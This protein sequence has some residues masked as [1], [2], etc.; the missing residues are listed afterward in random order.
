[1]C[2]FG[3]GGSGQPGR[4][5]SVC[6]A[7]GPRGQRLR[8]CCGTSAGVGG[9]PGIGFPGPDVDAL[10]AALLTDTGGSRVVIVGTDA[11][12]PPAGADESPVTLGD[13]GCRRDPGR[14]PPAAGPEDEPQMA[15]ARPA[16]RAGL[17]Y[18]GPLEGPPV[19]R[20]GNRTALRRGGVV[21]AAA[22]PRRRR[23]RL[24][25][26][27]RLVGPSPGTARRHAFRPLRAPRHPRI[28]RPLR[29]RRPS[30]LPGPPRDRP[31]RRRCHRRSSACSTTRT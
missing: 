3:G 6:G 15:R 20:H 13:R 14:P 30:G 19:L 4:R 7:G 5:R 23:H 27:P 12:V 8:G 31:D 25:L 1:M 29:P 10:V 16:R 11:P 18:G 9:G 22:G 21:R 26:G 2:R 24:R 28:S 17:A